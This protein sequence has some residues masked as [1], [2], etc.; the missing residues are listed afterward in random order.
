VRPPALACLATIGIADYVIHRR[1]PSWLQVGALDE[2]A[3]LATAFLLNERPTPA[4]LIGALLPDLDHVPLMFGNPTPGDSRPP[5]HS[6]LTVLP[7]LAVSRDLAAGIL[8]HFARDLALHA[9]APVFWPLSST[10]LRVPYALY[11]A[12]VTALAVRARRRD[13]RVR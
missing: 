5:T 9:G 13:S 1:S 3:H 6:I 11:A 2:P 7:A 10:S 12:A 8:A 4:Y